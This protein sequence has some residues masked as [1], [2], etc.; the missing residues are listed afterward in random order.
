MRLL[1]S[2]F[3]LFNI[4][5]CMSTPEISPSQ[6]KTTTDKILINKATAQEAK[7]EYKKLQAQRQNE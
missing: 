6:E 1:F 3:I 4:T 7:D 5:A 2:L